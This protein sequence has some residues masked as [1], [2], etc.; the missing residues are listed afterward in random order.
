[1][2]HTYLRLLCGWLLSLSLLSFSSCDLFEYHPYEGNIE[3]KNLTAEHVA[4]IK[5]TES[6]LS[7]L[8]P[9]RFAFISDTQGFFAETKDMVND[10]NRRDVAFVLH[11]GDLT[12]YAFT[13]EFERMHR[14]LAKLKVPYVTVIGNHDCLG[15]GPKLYQRMYGPL[16]HSFTYGKN[17]FIFLN[18]NFLEFNESVPDVNWLQQ[19][20]QNAPGT[21][22]KFV[23]SH[24]SPDNGEANPHK[25]RAYSLLMRQYDVKLSLHGH[26]HN[27]RADQ[28]YDDGILYVTTASA[29]KRSYV[30]VTVLGDQ[31]TYEKIDF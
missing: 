10:I 7:P 12:N 11:G 29:D 27:Y 13:D 28:L 18:T 22:N 2:K 23:I 25:E 24:I 19:E 14:E 9:L 20:L 17:K 8:T 16:N 6:S 30:L 5:A 3:F 31:V 4:R 21:P 1:M 15:E 26:T